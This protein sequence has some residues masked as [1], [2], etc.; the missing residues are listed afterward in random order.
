MLYPLLRM[1]LL[2]SALVH[3]HQYKLDM[4]LK[5]IV[6][7]DMVQNHEISLQTLKTETVVTNITLVYASHSR[8]LKNT[9][10]DIVR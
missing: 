9:L 6:L 7:R 8:V 4:S 3:C 5:Q 1:L 2:L 10:I